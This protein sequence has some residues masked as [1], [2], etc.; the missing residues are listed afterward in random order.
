[1][2]LNKIKQK[3]STVQDV[4]FD[5]YKER[6]SLIDVNTKCSFFHEKKVILWR[7]GFMILLHLFSL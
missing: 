4:Y 3:F 5:K 2:G 7:L 1:M 6:H